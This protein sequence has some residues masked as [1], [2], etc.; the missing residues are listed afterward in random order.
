MF[1]KDKIGFKRNLYYFLITHE[2]Q[3][4]PQRRYLRRKIKNLMY[5]TMIIMVFLG[6]IYRFIKNLLNEQ[7]EKEEK[8]EEEEQKIE[9]IVEEQKTEE[10]PRKKSIISKVIRKTKNYFKQSVA[11]LSSDFEIKYADNITERL[12]NV[13]GIEEVREEVEEIIS[14]L[15]NPDSYIEAGAKLPKGVLLCGKPGTGKT[16]IARAIAGESGVNF[17]Y[18]TGSDFDEM[19]VG[20]GAARMRKLFK[21]AR[22]NSPCIIFID[23]VDSL[24]AASR[25][26]GEHSSSRATINQFLAEMDG[27]TKLEKLIVIGATNHEKDLDPAAVRPGRFDKKI[28]ISVPDESGRTEI[29]KFYLNKIKLTK[30]N[31]DPVYIAKLTP[32]FTGAEIENLINLAIVRAVN[33]HKGE[34][35]MDDISESRDR[36]FMGIA[37]K[38]YSMSEKRRYHVA[39]HEAGHTLVCYKSESCRKTLEKVTVIPRGPAMGVTMRLNDE[40]ALNS[41][42]EFLDFID[43]CMGGHVA[44]EL[45]YG[46]DHVTA[47][48]SSDLDKATNI[49][50]QMAKKYGMYGD[51]VGYIYV[52]DEGYTWDRD[53]TSD[54][55]K[56]IIDS[57]VKEILKESHDRVYSLLKKDANELKNIAQTVFQ[58]DTLNCNVYLCR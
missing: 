44:E 29:I 32:G 11:D 33:L 58:Y 31:L 37:N 25:R 30:K 24:L 43:M 36:V 16:L 48:C 26:K 6:V 40:E 42:N 22:E 53:E 52:E 28:H 3:V 13:K 17:I 57:M 50:Q 46:S 10:K 4:L 20:V 41:K 9:T 12:S 56:N 23:E 49:A 51:K 14:I 19:Y 7:E 21:T 45:V 2:D 35:D 47:G 38:K 18:L 8:D 15:K 39:L 27:F 34:V 55:Y 1:A 5:R 54:K